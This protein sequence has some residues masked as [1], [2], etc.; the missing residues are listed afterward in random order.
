MG[1]EK[2][3]RVVTDVVKMPPFQQ[4]KFDV[5]SCES[6]QVSKSPHGME[7]YSTEEC[8]GAKCL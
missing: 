1:D 6:C 5:L 7:K 3:S 4:C 2:I 8:T